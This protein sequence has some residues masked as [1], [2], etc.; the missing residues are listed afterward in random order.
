MGIQPLRHI[1][2]LLLFGAIFTSWSGFSPAGAE[3]Y[4]LKVMAR[5]SSGAQQFPLIGVRIHGTDG[6]NDLAGNFTNL[7][8]EWSLETADIGY[9]TPTLAV[10]SVERGYRFS[11]SEI[12]PSTETCPGRVCQIEATYDPERPTVV[13]GWSV[14]DQSGN[15][16]RNYPVYATGVSGSYAKFT[17]HDGYV[18]FTTHRRPASCDDGNSAIEDNWVAVSLGS[19]SSSRCTFKA[20]GGAL[21]CPN[22]NSGYRS[23]FH[24]V[25]SCAG[26]TPPALSGPVSYT[27]RVVGPNGAA[28]GGILFHG[29]NGFDGLAQRSTNGAG[30]LTFSTNQIAGTSATT[31]FTLVP[32][33]DAREFLP[34]MLELAPG[35]CANNTCVVTAIR[36]NNAQNVVKVSTSGL[37]GA[38]IRPQ[39]GFNGS[40]AIPQRTDGQGVAY[41]PAFARPTCSG[42]AD[43]FSV[44]VSASGCSF[45]SGGGQGG[46][47]FQI[48]PSEP[49]NTLTLAATCS[50]AF[51]PSTPVLSGKVV[52]VDGN[53]VAGIP[54]SVQQTPVATTAPDGSYAVS[55]SSSSSVRASVSIPNFAVDPAFVTFDS[56]TGDR[57]QNFGAVAP[58][59][60]IN[61]P[62]SG[63]PAC[64]PQETVTIS[65][66]V[67]DAAGNGI[68]GARVIDNRDLETRS[69][70]VTDAQGDFAFSLPAGG[71]HFVT[72]EHNQRPFDPAGIDYPDLIC[73]DPEANF[74]ATEFQSFILSGTVLDSVEMPMPQV[75]IEA[76]YRVGSGSEQYLEVF[77]NAAGDYVAHLPENAVYR[78][79]AVLPGFDFEPPQWPGD[80]NPSAPLSESLFGIDFRA[81]QPLNP[82]P[83]PTSTATATNTRAPTST[84]TAAPTA[85]P[86]DTQTPTR[87]PTV[88]AT[89]SGTTVP[90]SPPQPTATIA[91]PP[92]ATHTAVVTVAPTSTLT[93]THSPTFT[94]TPTNTPTSTSTPTPTTTP[95]STAPT[96]LNLTSMCSENPAVSRR[97]RVT[98]PFTSSINVG[99]SVHGTSQS[100]TVSVP[101]LG[102]AFFTTNTVTNLNGTS[103]PNTTQIFYQNTTLTK[104]SGGATCATPTPTATATATSTA[105]LTPTVT[106]SPEP[107]QAPQPTEAPT[108]TPTLVNTSTA[109]ATPT[110]THTPTATHT[111]TVTHTPTVTQTPT[112]THT[113]TSTATPTRTPTPTTTFTPTHTPTVTPTVTPS[114]TATVTPTPTRTSTATHTPTPTATSTATRT[115]TPTATFTV[116]NTPTVTPTRTPTATATNTATPVPTAEVRVNIRGFDGGPLTSVESSRLSRAQ[117]FL[118]IVQSTPGQA[119]AQTR[120]PLVAPFTQSISLIVG[121][122]YKITFNPGRGLRTASRPGRHNLTPKLGR[123]KLTLNFAVRLFNTGSAQSRAVRA[124]ARKEAEKEAEEEA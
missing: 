95:T 61:R 116:T 83:T 25:E 52:G 50:S 72:V 108:A 43:P 117:P 67:L 15:G 99:W 71:D 47:E 78:L 80:G 49:V 5:S 31:R 103:H 13:I 45:S 59:D 74:Q 110:E 115:P 58:V 18:L 123:S 62:R 111:A 96:T 2:A 64:A 7:Q 100:G 92:T 22:G 17:D 85:S 33:G 53:G 122:S 34:R 105:T 109:T 11:P 1:L 48:C 79:V 68:A 102:I 56:M 91:Q 55:V 29:N 41:F 94:A 12:S 57:R 36:N 38:V 35:S 30:T 3:R 76:H 121:Q 32:T 86:T 97:W 107:T 66:R 70:T 44:S 63:P 9:A 77:T 88:T 119:V 104:A 6:V 8:G 93:P 60:D 37:Q 114:N 24:R 81:L 16:F 14:T 98:N 118:S 39:A 106:S 21:L 42:V 19:P 65:G 23:G 73:S 40:G 89:S 69:E 87:T 82:T 120:V 113:P 20:P 112:R 51:Q 90:I 84:A 27:I 46:T 101:A 28:E 124:A 54:I 75:K 10:E 26:V 4:T